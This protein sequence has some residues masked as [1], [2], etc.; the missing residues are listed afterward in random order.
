MKSSIFI[1]SGILFIASCSSEPEKI[2]LRTEK[3]EQE[4][5]PKVEANA[6]LSVEIEGMMCEM[7]CGGSIRKELKSTGGVA[8][9][10]YDFEEDREVNTAII[11]FD[12]NKVSA[13]EMIKRIKTMND[14]QFTVHS[15]Q[16][17]KQ[18][19]N[20]SGTTSSGSDEKSV[21]SMD[22]HSFQ[23]PNLISILKD[24]ILQ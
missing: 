20:A 7:G 15:Y 17:E 5:A 11:S 16:V 21:V 3:G 13:A 10:Q 24:F 18:T 19:D 8:R 2:H 14:K 4:Q 6:T 9:V 1:F 12:S 22:D 23:L